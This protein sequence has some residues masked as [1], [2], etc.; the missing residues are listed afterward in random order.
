MT[1]KDTLL[2][3]DPNLR[4]RLEALASRSGMSLETLAQ[5]VLL[6]HADEQERLADELAED[7]ERW[8][9]YLATGQSIPFETVREKLRSLAAAAARQTDTP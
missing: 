5:S 9:Q 1:S 8:Q 3:I 4:A 7:E 2:E 6:A